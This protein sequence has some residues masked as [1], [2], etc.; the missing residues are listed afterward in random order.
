VGQVIEKCNLHCCKEHILDYNIHDNHNPSVSP[1]FLFLA[2][3]I[4]NFCDYVI[5][6]RFQVGGL[7]LSVSDVFVILE[8]NKYIPE[9]AMSYFSVFVRSVGTWFVVGRK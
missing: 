5:F 3:N 4:C 7:W 1:S 2:S 8:A 6:R 9:A